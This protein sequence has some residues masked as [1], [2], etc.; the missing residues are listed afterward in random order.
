MAMYQPTD[1]Q[2]A[3][4]SKQE[5]IR[6]KDYPTSEDFD[7][8]L[9]CQDALLP[10]GLLS[11]DC[12]IFFEPHSNNYCVHNIMN[13]YTVFLS[14]QNL[15]ITLKPYYHNRGS[16]DKFVSSLIPSA[17]KG[18]M[19]NKKSLEKDFNK[20][21]YNTFTAT[22]YMEKENFPYI[23]A[24]VSIEWE[25]FPCIEL[26]FNNVFNKYKDDFINWVSYAVQY[27]EKSGVSWVS[28][29]TQGIG[30]GLIYEEIIKPLF[31]FYG[32]VINNNQLEDKFN[33]WQLEKLFVV[34]N[35]IS[36]DFRTAVKTGNTIKSYITD[37]TQGVEAKS[38]T[39][40]DMETFYNMWF[41]SND[42]NPL[43]IETGDR[44]FSIV[45]G[46]VS[47]T[48]LVTEPIHEFI[49]KLKEE[50]HDFCVNVALLSVDVSKARKAI[51]NETKEEAINANFTSFER[52]KY[53]IDNNMMDEITDG[54]EGY[55]LASVSDG[56]IIDV[57]RVQNS[58]IEG[59]LGLDDKND[60]YKAFVSKT[61][62]QPKMQKAF[63]T[64]YNKP[65]SKKINGV[66][67]RYTEIKPLFLIIEE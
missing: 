17:Y 31:G 3:M 62:T 35:E 64:A 34:A 36:I 39:T 29:G 15:E 26:V 20:S 53:L 57:V 23:G 66:V 40:K 55:N 2:L 8:L 27:R 19:P 47:L 49:D 14:K 4:L 25:R 59:L 42:N 33:D 18:F 54:L 65:K 41:H 9:E 56:D 32:R 60:L 11:I 58:L 6:V 50:V 22:E 46:G 67:K 43:L 51:M 28:K 38:V 24:K 52:L 45:D 10:Y 44:R 13:G 63:R 30:K 37:S 48:E 1:K 12:R 7:Y 5:R 21:T 61:F 16:V